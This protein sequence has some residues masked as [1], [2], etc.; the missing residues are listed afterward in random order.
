MDD[1]NAWSKDHKEHGVLE[2]QENHDDHECE[3]E[4]IIT[5]PFMHEDKNGGE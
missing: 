1:K 4:L 5:N 2:R 3:C